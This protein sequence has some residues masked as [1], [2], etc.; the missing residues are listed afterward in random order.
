MTVYCALHNIYSLFFSNVGVFG[1][2]LGF[3]ALS[4]GLGLG[5]ESLESQPDE[6]DKWHI[7]NI[8]ELNGHTVAANHLGLAGSSQIP[9]I[10]PVP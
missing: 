2:G 4:L 3:E 6:I 9:S 1:F 10:F 8:H 7:I 5:L